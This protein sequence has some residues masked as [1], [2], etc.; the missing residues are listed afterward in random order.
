MEFTQPEAINGM[1]IRFGDDE[2]GFKY[3][4]IETTMTV[5]EFYSSSVVKMSVSAINKVVSQQGITVD[6]DEK[7]LTVTGL[8]ESGE[9]KLLMDK[10]TGAVLNLNIPDSDFSMDFSGFGFMG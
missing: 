1:Y 3:K 9:F 5:D 2:I 7:T 10:E 4:D 8:T 6:M